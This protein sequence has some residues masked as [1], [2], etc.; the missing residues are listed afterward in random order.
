M[1]RLNAD[2]TIYGEKLAVHQAHPWYSELISVM[3]SGKEAIFSW[4]E[5]KFINELKV[6]STV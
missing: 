1:A 5:E 2:K 4:G 3:N 6:S